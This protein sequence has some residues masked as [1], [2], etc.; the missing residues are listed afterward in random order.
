MIDKKE[1]SFLLKD[2][3]ANKPT[4][5]NFHMTCPDDTVK[6][7]IGEKILP[8]DWDFE[9]QRAK[10]NGRLARDINRIIDAIIAMIPGLKSEC[11][12]TNRVF[13]SKDLHNALDVILQDKRTED[14]KK[15]PARNMFSDF[16]TIVDGMKSGEIKTPGKSKKWYSEATISNYEKRAFVK[17]KEFYDKKKYAAAWQEIDLDLYNAF[18]NWCHDN[19]L[20]NNSI[21]TYIK[22][23]KRA[24]KIALKN[25]WHA[26]N[27]FKDEDFMTLKEETPDIYLDEPKIEIF[28]KYK[29]INENHEIARDWAVLDCYLGL[30]ISDL[31]RITEDDFASDLFQFVNQKTGAHVAIPIHPFAGAILNKWKGLPPAMKDTAFRDNLK[32]AAKIAGFKEKFIYVV[33]KG[34]KTQSFEYEEWECVSPHTFRRS[35]I[36]N[37]LKMGIPH[38]Q[39]MKL[40]G[41]KKYD[42][43]QRYFKQTTIEVANEMKDH[44]FFNKKA[45]GLSPGQA[46]ASQRKNEQGGR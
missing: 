36:T 22:C 42:T 28:Y 27:I 45:P 44:A 35:F 24:G 16:T 38:A 37:L 25:G 39:V 8:G 23:W 46:D 43:L 29:Y 2:T 19:N 12:R 30:R 20:S 1:C 10:G 18:L 41:I 5:I 14:K 15:A 40:A 9:F 21:G 3:K 31:R 17:I 33:T 26:N 34:G 32:Q 7:S 6:R 13:S 11:R 4:P